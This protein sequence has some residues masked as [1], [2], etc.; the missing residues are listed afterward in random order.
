[1][2]ST[3]QFA[4]SESEL[5]LE[6]NG[7]HQRL[8]VRHHWTLLDVLRDQLDLTGAKRGCD[9]GECGSC[10]V[11]LDGMPVYSCQ[12]LAMQ[13]GSR[14][15]VTIEG[16]EGL[17]G[18]GRLDPL[19]QCFLDTPVRI[20]YPRLR[21][22]GQGAAGRQRRPQRSGHPRS[23]GWKPVPLQ[24]LRPNHPVGTGGRIATAAKISRTFITKGTSQSCKQMVD[25]RSRR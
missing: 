16:L 3:Q 1:M 23:A 24:R 22:V 13:V 12:I 11:L 15:I 19:Q 2:A 9:R 14:G 6:L 4:P 5:T 18:D 10:T 7:Q 25:R 20:L 17:A 8:K 21:T